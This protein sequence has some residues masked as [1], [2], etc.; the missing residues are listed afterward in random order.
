[1]SLINTYFGLICVG[2]IT[3]YAIRKPEK[4]VSN[5]RT[6]NDEDDALM[7]NSAIAV[8]LNIVYHLIVGSYFSMF[9]TGSDGTTCARMM[10]GTYLEEGGEALEPEGEFLSREV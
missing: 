9:W 3:Y 6:Y 7:N 4:T 10:N 5:R 2:I 8:Y 1:M